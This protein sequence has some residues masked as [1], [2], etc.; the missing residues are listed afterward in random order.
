MN[1]FKETNQNNKTGDSFDR[2]GTKIFPIEWDIIK[3]KDICEVVNGKAFKPSEWDKNKHGLKIVRIQNLKGNDDYNYYNGDYDSKYIIENEELLFSWSATI[4]SFIWKGE[5]ALLNQHIFKIKMK[6]VIYKKYFSYI[7]KDIAERAK[8]D[9]HGGGGMLHINKGTMENYL[10]LIP[11]DKQEILNITK[12]LDQQQGLIDSYKEKLSLL[13][14]QETYYQ[15]EL[16]SGRLRIR[17]TDESIN[18]ATQQG[19]YLN[20]DLVEGKEKEFEE[21]IAVDFHSKVGFYKETDFKDGIYN[22]KK[23][24]LPFDWNI[25]KLS[26]FSTKV[27]G[28]KL[29][30]FDKKE[31]GML[32][33]V[34]ANLLRLGEVNEFALDGVSVEEND[35]TILWDGENAGNVGIGNKGF[36]AST[37]SKLTINNL[38]IKPYYVYRQLSFNN[39]YLKLWREGSTIPH[40]SKDFFDLYTIIIPNNKMEQE[41]IGVFFNPFEEQKNLIKEKI[42][43][44]EEKMDYLMD[45]LL[46][47]RIRVK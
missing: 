33:V 9:A 18:Y 11:K 47:G 32:P 2:F 29:D 27:K 6:D 41:C 14:E 19:W 24:K 7:L 23:R 30:S 4:D 39:Y 44:E 17:L 3:V 10:F 36:I 5:K 40:M 35:I 37:M 34:N 21:W 43:V 26:D 16:L 22:N 46:S 25:F 8:A 13:E 28:K 12:I 20:D 31:S 42:K 45:E 38:L 15:D 1:I